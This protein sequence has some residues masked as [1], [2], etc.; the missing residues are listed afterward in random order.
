MI[1]P[2]INISN[3]IM[4]HRSPWYWHS[5]QCFLQD[6]LMAFC[7]LGTDSINLQINSQIHS[8]I[9]QSY[10]NMLSN[11]PLIW[12]FRW[13]YKVGLICNKNVLNMIKLDIF[14][15][16]DI[17]LL[18]WRH[19]LL[20]PISW[21]ACCFTSTKLEDIIFSNWTIHQDKTL[22]ITTSEFILRSSSSLWHMNTTTL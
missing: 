7:F 1:S 10:L 4:Y 21:K 8:E 12:H 13:G 11:F 19:V 18:Q 6:F 14:T 20:S 15:G 2:I 5:I 9:D 22:W 17:L 16:F 3:T